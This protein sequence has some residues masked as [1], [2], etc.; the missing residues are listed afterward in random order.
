[1]LC[2]FR[3]TW[4]AT[5]GTGAL[6]PGSCTELHGTQPG[7][8]VKGVSTAKTA[9]IPQ[10]VEMHDALAMHDADRYCNTPAVCVL[11]PYSSAV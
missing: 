9:Y 7:V 10:V 3:G 1:M 4:D 5:P 11:G 2:A 8:N 6:E